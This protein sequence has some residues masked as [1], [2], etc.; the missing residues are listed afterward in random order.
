MEP[1]NVQQIKTHFADFILENRKTTEETFPGVLI[2]SCFEELLEKFGG[3]EIRKKELDL[4]SFAFEN[5][6]KMNFILDNELKLLEVKIIS[7]DSEKQFS[8]NVLRKFNSQDL[9]SFKLP[10]Q[11]REKTGND[12]YIKDICN[13][14]QNE[15]I[16]KIGKLTTTKPK[17]REQNPLRINEIYPPSNRNPHNNPEPLGFRPQIRYDPVRPPTLGGNDL[18]PIIDPINPNF[19]I[20][21]GGNRMGPNHSFFRRDQDNNRR[22]GFGGGNGFGG[23]GGGLGGLW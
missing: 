11:D 10:F 12:V 2:Y 3:F 6:Y 18:N 8:V 17:E 4:S 7:L 23:G 20:N 9:Y 19:P 1:A 22:G 15:L 13:I 16:K 14:I 5:L 21:D